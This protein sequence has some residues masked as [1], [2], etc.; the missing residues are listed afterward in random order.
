MI[1]TYY[2]KHT[3]SCHDSSG[4]ASHTNLVRC[5]ASSLDYRCTATACLL[6][7]CHCVVALVAAVVS[8]LCKLFF[9]RIHHCY[10]ITDMLLVCT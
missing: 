4:S 5:V 1:I 3:N 2:D 8:T 7:R 10:A 6:Q 9:Q